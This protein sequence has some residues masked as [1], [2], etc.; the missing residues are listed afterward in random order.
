MR[1]VILVALAM[2]AAASVAAADV[3]CPAS[4]M[5]VG[6][7][8]YPSYG[9]SA[10]LGSGEDGVEYV[11]WDAGTVCGSGCYDLPMGWLESRGYNTLY[12]NPG[13][14]VS[15]EDEY[16]IEGPPA[17]IAFEVVFVLHAEICPGGSGFASFGTPNSPPHDFPIAGSGD[18][19][20]AIAIVKAPLEHFSINATVWAI[21]GRSDGESDV[22]GIIRF[23]GLPA[24]YVVRSCQ[25]Y[26]LA[27]PVRPAT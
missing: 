27:T 20:A 1:S 11:S 4:W 14:S 10:T 15:V 8:A 16:W 13:T 19:E 18:I 9:P 6:D 24:G 3:S 17:Q 21:G 22:R 26:D 7:V 23:R 12:G 25:G 2:M 5:N